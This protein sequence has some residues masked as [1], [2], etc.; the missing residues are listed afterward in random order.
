MHHTKNVKADVK[1]LKIL[2]CA[3]VYLKVELSSS[4]GAT[5][6]NFQSGASSNGVG[7]NK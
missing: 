2:I 4:L 1:M 7:A 3:H 5:G 6:L